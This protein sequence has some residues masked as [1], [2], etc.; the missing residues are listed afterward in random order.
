MNR[1]DSFD[2]YARGYPADSQDL[3][4]VINGFSLD[5]EQEPIDR[6]NGLVFNTL[7]QLLST[8]KRLSLNKELLFS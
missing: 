2:F 4:L 1:P 3:P 7:L 6:P 5:Y 8:E